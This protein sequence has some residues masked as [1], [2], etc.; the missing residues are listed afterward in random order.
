ML[1]FVLCI[2]IYFYRIMLQ[3]MIND[4]ISRAE[5]EMSS[6][7]EKFFIDTYSIN[8]LCHMT[9]PSQ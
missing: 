5:N 7:T 1:D 9:T 4:T 6:K 8:P 2:F 3:N